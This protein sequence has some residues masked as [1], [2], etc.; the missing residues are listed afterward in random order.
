MET[1]SKTSHAWL[2]L[3][4]VVLSVATV[5]A[6]QKDA[7]HVVTEA[8]YEKERYKTLLVFNKYRSVRRERYVCETGWHSNNDIACD[9]AIC[10]GL[11]NLNGA[12]NTRIGDSHII[13]TDGTIQYYPDGSCNSPN[14]CTCTKAGFYSGGPVCSMCTAISNC[15]LETCTTA[16]NQVCSRCEGTVQELVGYRAYVPSSDN[17]ACN[18]ACSWRSDSTRCYPG[19]CPTELASSCTCS[20]GFGGLHCQNIVSQADII[21][22]E[23]KLT[24][25]DGS[26]VIAPFDT[27]AGPSASQNEIW[28][29]ILSPQNIFYKWNGQF[30]PILPTHHAY[31]TETKVGVTGGKTQ[32]ILNRGTTRQ[33]YERTCGGSSRDDP[34]RAVFTCSATMQPAE[35]SGSLT[36]PFQHGDQLEF[37]FH[38]D[39]GGFVKVENKETRMIETHYFN[40]NTKTHQF[41][42]H[43]DTIVPYHCKIASGCGESMLTVKDITNLTHKIFCGMA[44]KMTMLAYTR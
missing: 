7:N 12:C 23:L 40:G 15:N 36:V 13:Y 29:N 2:A 5:A 35:Y 43:F 32:L 6:L 20:S 41:Q 19:S 9:Y 22:N 31:I 37:S 3:T 25:S 26:I 44:G 30:H 24:A 18:K 17:R 38:A 10:N 8:F 27:N 21:Y 33:V 4:V 42:I 11:T 34:N 16:T 39:V 14:S 1:R 28:T